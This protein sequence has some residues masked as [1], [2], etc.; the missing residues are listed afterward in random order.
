M[1]SCQKSLSKKGISIKGC[2][3]YYESDDVETASGKPVVIP[4]FILENVVY[5][6]L[7]CPNLLMKLENSMCELENIEIAQQNVLTL[8]DLSILPELVVNNGR[9]TLASEDYLRFRMPDLNPI[10]DL[11]N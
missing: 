6:F 9:F 10:Q 3:K 5:Q 4:I 11:L 8:K 1:N 7:C 2:W